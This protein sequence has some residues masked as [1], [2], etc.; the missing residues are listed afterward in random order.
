MEISVKDI[1]KQAKQAGKAVQ[2]TEKFIQDL[3]LQASTVQDETTLK[4]LQMR[5]ARLTYRLNQ[6]KQELDQVQDLLRR[7]K[8]DFSVYAQKNT[9]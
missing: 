5:V 9:F 7:V 2:S 1:E 3:K 8:L 6:E 4:R